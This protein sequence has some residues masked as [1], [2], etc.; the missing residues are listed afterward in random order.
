MR[1]AAAM[2]A[3]PVNGGTDGDTRSDDGRDQRRDQ[4]VPT[5]VGGEPD[6][7]LSRNQEN[8]GKGTVALL[9]IAEST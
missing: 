2:P 1:R 7:E 3:S 6:L 9:R 5:R 8:D 4:S